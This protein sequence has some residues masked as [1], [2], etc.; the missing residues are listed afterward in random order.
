VSQVLDITPREIEPAPA[1]GTQIRVEYLLG[2]TASGGR[3]AL[4]L[5]ASRVL[6]ADELLAVAEAKAA[7]GPPAEG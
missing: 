2:A 3:F 7:P 6:S 5:D 4:L 1:F